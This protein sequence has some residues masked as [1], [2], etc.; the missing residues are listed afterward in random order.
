MDNFFPFWVASP[1]AT[2]GPWDEGP[3][4]DPPDQQCLEEGVS[5]LELELASES[6]GQLV[7]A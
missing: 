3:R 1:T 4:Q 7:K 6:P 2:K 5:A